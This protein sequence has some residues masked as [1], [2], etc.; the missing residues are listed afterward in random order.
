MHPGAR[1]VRKS[2]ALFAEL[3]GFVNNAGFFFFH[4]PERVPA[5]KRPLTI[6][7]CAFVFFFLY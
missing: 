4:V 3:G 7:I 5:G 2:V 6:F 1:I